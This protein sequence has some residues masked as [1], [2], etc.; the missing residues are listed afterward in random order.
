MALAPVGRYAHQ[1]RA[2][3]KTSSRATAHETGLLFTNESS[4]EKGQQN[5]SQKKPRQLQEELSKAQADRIS[6]QSAY[7]MAQAASPESLP[8]VL[9]DSSLRE[10]Q[11]KLTDLRRQAADLGATYRPEYAKVKKIQAQ[12]VTLEGA[13]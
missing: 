5:V 4:G 1:A 11:S 2:L 13:L 9:N 6:R 7:E 10:Y 12:I 8:D 3:P